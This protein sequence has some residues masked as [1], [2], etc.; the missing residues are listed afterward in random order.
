MKRRENKN[1]S[2]IIAPVINTIALTSLPT[3]KIDSATG[4]ES[5]MSLLNK[6]DTDRNGK[7]T[8]SEFSVSFGNDSNKFLALHKAVNAN[9]PADEAQ[10]F[11]QKQTDLLHIRLHLLEMNAKFAKKALENFMS[12]QN[13]RNS[14]DSSRFQS[15][16]SEVAESNRAVEVFKGQYGSLKT[17]SPAIG[18]LLQEHGR[19]DSNDA[20]FGELTARIAELKLELDREIQF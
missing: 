10:Q 3:I 1:M 13:S 2:T 8:F 11:Q 18:K 4:N 17:A 5:T 7:I 12:S 14:F 16:T 6:L 20:N 15:L 19:T 9:N